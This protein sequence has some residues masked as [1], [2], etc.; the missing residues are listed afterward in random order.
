MTTEIPAQTQTILWDL[1]G[2]LLDSFGAYREALTE[3]LPGYGRPVPSEE[4][5]LSNFHGSLEDALKGVMGVVEPDELQKIIGS[6][7]RVQ[8]RQFQLIEHY[9]CPDA[10]DLARHADQ[11]DLR[12]IVVTNRDRAGGQLASPCSIVERSELKRYI[13][14]IVCGNDSEHRKPNPAVLNT[15]AADIDP[16]RT[17]VVGDQHVDAEFALYLGAMAVIVSRN[18]NTAALDEYARND[19]VQVVSSLF[20]VRVSQSE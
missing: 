5:L 9:L 18:G 20:D 4:V 19:K 1:D 6:L 3:I 16:S 2:T 15:L 17:V 12:Q 13:S 14:H 8:N 11:L 10:M 7:W